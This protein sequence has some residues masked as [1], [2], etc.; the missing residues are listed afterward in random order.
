M[1]SGTMREGVDGS[2][3]QISLNTSGCIHLRS[4]P[5][6]SRI[7]RIDEADGVAFPVLHFD[8]ATWL[9]P[10]MSARFF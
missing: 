8:T 5:R 1:G 9:T 10:Q 3:I 6:V 2:G 4:M 7:F